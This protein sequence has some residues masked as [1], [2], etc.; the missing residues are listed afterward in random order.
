M[1]AT[2]IRTVQSDLAWVNGHA[3]IASL[4][5]GETLLRV[6]LGWGFYGDTSTLT[7]LSVVSDNIQV[8]GVVTTVGNG[9]ET[10]PN[11][12][13]ASTNAAPP[14]QRWIYWEARAPRLVSYDGVAEQAI[15]HDSGPQE[16]VDTEAQVA[17]AGIPG[18]D[19]LNV[20]ASWASARAWDPTGNTQ[21][22]FWASLLYKPTT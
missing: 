2:W 7:D 3:L 11:A 20:W 5:A 12:R 9:T 19:T 18:G 1:S 15:W 6:H 22:W 10:V 13:T 16:R 14:T 4:A 17:A 8:F 21:L